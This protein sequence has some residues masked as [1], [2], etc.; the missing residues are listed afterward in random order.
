MMISQAASVEKHGHDFRW[1]GGKCGEAAEKPVTIS[2]RQ[3]GGRSAKAR[4]SAMAIP[5]VPGG[6]CKQL[7]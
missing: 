7:H 5:R 6:N 3:N 1:K 4:N 2:K